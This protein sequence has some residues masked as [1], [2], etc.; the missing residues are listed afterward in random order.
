MEKVVLV[1]VKIEGAEPNWALSEL[2]E[3][4]ALL[5]RTVRADIVGEIQCNRAAQDPAL[6]IGKG[7]AQEIAALAR[8]RGAETVIFNNDLSPTQ[9]RNLEETLGVKT[10]DRTQLILDIF[11]RHARS[12]EGKVQVELAQLQYLLPRLSGKG[13]ELSRLGGGIGTR[14]PGEQKLEVDRRKIRKRIDHLKED[15]ARLEQRRSALRQ[16]RACQAVPSVALVG[17]TNAG[18]ST[19]LNS[20][21]NAGVIARDEMFSTLDPITRRCVL[22]QSGQTVLFSDTVGFLHHLPHHLIEAF[23]A[24]LE[25]VTEADV[26]LVVLDIAGER[27]YQHHAAIW[28][29]LRELGADEKN[30]LYV[31]NKTD[32]LPGDAAIRRFQNQYG[33]SVAISAKIKENLAGL[34]QQVE[35]R[36]N[37]L[38]QKIEILIPHDKSGL[39]HQLYEQGRVTLCEYRDEG[40]YLE[41]VVPVLFAKK[42]LT[43]LS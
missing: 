40:A 36:L 3:E 21:T 17:Y 20:L 10:I 41:A 30:V 13:A 2:A 4:L 8:E 12:Q 9:Q 34:L 18:K 31:L 26:L 27:V 14:G 33:P 38:T 23:K 7:K 15:I 35:N 19:L 6:Y 11:A 39:A 16:R 24:T 5:S 1:T 32:L 42:I 37:H 28:E 22:P 25:V 29:V 43:E